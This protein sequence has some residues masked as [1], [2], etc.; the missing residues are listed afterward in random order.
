MPEVVCTFL[1]PEAR[2]EP[3]NCTTQS[4]NR[5]LGSFAQITLELAVQ[6]LDGIE[7]RRILR[8]V[9]NTRPCSLNRLLDARDFVGFEVVHHDDVI[10]LQRWKQAL[11]NIGAEYLSRHRPLDDHRRGQSVVAQSGHEGDR[12]P[13]AQ[14]D[15]ADHPHPAR[16]A[17]G[18]PRHVGADGGLVDKHQ[19]GWIK[20]ALL[21]Y[22][23]S[24][25]AGH[26]G[27]LS[28]CGLQAYF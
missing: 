27:P 9:A 26:I 11:L 16:S 4:G 19:P 13:L 17:S 28:L 2:H 12:L 15:A 25:R 20:H 8:K 14:W 1:S 18:K 10:A 3:A 5:S 21:S 22:P 7:I 6:Q 23:A 24:P